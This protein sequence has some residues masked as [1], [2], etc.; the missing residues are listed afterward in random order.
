[1]KTTLN[2]IRAHGP[3]A[4]GWKKLL[5]NLGKTEADDEPLAIT[6]ILD[7][8]GLDDALWCLRAVDGYEREMRMYAVHCARSVQHLL[9]DARSIEA[10]DVAERHANGLA[11]DEE[12]A[13]A[14]AAARGAASYAASSAAWGGL[15][16]TLRVPLRFGL[17]GRLRVGLHGA[18]RG[19]LRVPL[20]GTLRGRLRVP[21]LLKR[22]LI[23]CAPCALKSNSV[24]R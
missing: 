9:T 20:R 3:C 7:S 22:R 23:C 1:M 18:L 15:H 4:K 2:K 11:T 17:R 5:K 8:N 21:L 13:A 24:M 16:G 6:T 12:L 14:R 10:I 19:T